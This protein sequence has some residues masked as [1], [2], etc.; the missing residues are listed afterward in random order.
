MINLKFKILPYFKELDVNRI[1]NAVRFDKIIVPILK[2]PKEELL[3]VKR[4]SVLFTEHNEEEGA[5]ELSKD[6]DEI[7]FDKFYS[8]NSISNRISRK[9]TS[10]EYIADVT[11]ICYFLNGKLYLIPI[12]KSSCW[13]FVVSEDNLNGYI[14]LYPGI[15]E[16]EKP[17]LETILSFI[18][19]KRV[20]KSIF[21]EIIREAIKKL[22]L[23]RKPVLNVLVVRGKQQIDGV[24]ARIDF[25]VDV[26]TDFKPKLTE[27]G[28]VDFYHLHIINP[29]EKDQEIAIFY[30]HQEGVDGEDIFGNRIIAKKAKPLPFPSGKNTYQD[31]ENPN[32][33]RSEINGNLVFKNDIISVD[34]LYVIKGNVDF[35][36]GSIETK[37]S[38]QV[39]GNIKKGFD[40]QA[41]NNIDVLGYIEDCN[42]KVGGNI[43]VKSGFYGDGSGI[44]IADGKVDLK[45]VHSQ[46]VYSRD[47]I[48]VTNEV[49]DSKLFA[50]KKIQVIGGKNMAVYGGKL[51]AGD[52][53]EANCIGNEYNVNTIIEV[54]YDYEYQEKYAKNSL[55]IKEQEGTNS[56]LVAEIEKLKL[57]MGIKLEQIKIFNLLIEQKKSIIIKSNDNNQDAEQLKK[58]DEILK[59]IIIQSQLNKS[60]R[61]ELATKLID[62]FS[63][64]SSIIQC[65]KENEE[66]QKL[67][68]EPTKAKIVINKF[69]YPGVILQINKRRFVIDQKLTN[70]TFHLSS[71]NDEI[72]IV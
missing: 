35:S 71:E 66:Y 4:G 19:K 62:Y 69:I 27:D 56:G 60:N 15:G 16:F 45:Y 53:V 54:G 7:S 55:K 44:L 10:N 42:V 40:V 49:I 34:E 61:I 9:T 12:S 24:D 5:I 46:T 30:S 8:I 2:I 47:S 17:D 3:L 13:E 41:E 68:Y 31:Q 25:L 51:I 38:L 36:T 6:T 52:L 70:K 11:G 59:K 28:R 64:F 58:I 1:K 21:T 72:I 32:L 23:N 57:Y 48:N 20:K 39:Q 67:I 63:L 18:D 65:K 33:I 22:M 14:N 26:E 37:G 50:L 43:S 29:V